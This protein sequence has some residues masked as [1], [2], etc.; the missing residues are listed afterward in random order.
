MATAF[1]HQDLTLSREFP[2]ST[3]PLPHIPPN[4]L[5]F[6]P[7]HFFLHFFPTY[8]PPT[9]Y[10]HPFTRAAD[11]SPARAADTMGKHLDHLSF[12]GCILEAKRAFPPCF[13]LPLPPARLPLGG[14]GLASSGGRR[15]LARGSPPH[16]DLALPTAPGRKFVPGTLVCA[17]H[18]GGSLRS[19]WSAHLGRGPPARG[20]RISAGSEE[21]RRRVAPDAQSERRR[22]PEA[23][24]RRLSGPDPLA[25]V[26]ALTHA[27]ALLRRK[28]RQH[29]RRRI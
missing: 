1:L 7:A 14:R 24:H 25:D 5:K 20:C 4:H 19:A 11:P 12:S 3:S 26:L 27:L 15:R 9:A 16:V 29:T 28:R 13:S 8:I 10:P 21:G 6:R 2:P 18:A 23:S 17:P 22:S